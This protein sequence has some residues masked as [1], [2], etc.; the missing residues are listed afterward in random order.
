M[1]A[2]GGCIGTGLFFGSAKSIHNTGP[3]IILAYLLCG[4]VMYIIMR[5]LGEMTVDKPSSGAWSEYA[6]N[7]ISPYAGFVTG[8]T[9]WF[10]YTVVC[11]VEL[12][13]VAFFL[14]FWHFSIADWITCLVLL[15]VFSATQLYSVKLFGEFEFWFAGI[16]VFAIISMIGFS[17]Y[18]LFFNHNIHASL[19]NNLTS[20]TNKDIFFAHGMSGFMFSLVVVMFSF[21]GTEFV[22]IAAGEAENPRKSIPT[23]INGVIVRIILFYVLTIIMILCLYPFEKLST[24][25]SPF[26]DVFQK[27]GIPAAAL[28]MNVVAITA[29][30]S[31]FNSCLYASS[32]MLSN[33]SHNNLAPKFLSKTSKKGIPVFAVLV[34]SLFVGIA[35]L[36][37]YLFPDKAI[38][39]LLTIATAA[40][41]VTWFMIL[42]SQLC[43]RFKYPKKKLDYKLGLFPFSNIFAMFLLILVM[44]AM[45]FMDDMRLSV[46]ATPIWVFALS[47]VYII[48]KKKVR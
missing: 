16:K 32:R 28:V 31:A 5:A 40:I 39:Y 7:Y 34:T 22:S 43:F 20:Y 21:G 12:T 19:L 47:I 15:V 6:N 36:V 8:W 24:E 33:L 41:L 4:V 35:V 30:L 18:L 3:S 48:K 9:A 46:I 44:I 26:V 1:I 11:M 42:L 10:E 13:A 45:L 17:I 27:V 29:A 2:L 23:A 14:N 38:M 25:V 37:N